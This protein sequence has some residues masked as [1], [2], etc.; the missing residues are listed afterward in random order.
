VPGELTLSTDL[1]W[2]FRGV[3]PL[4][5]AGVV[6]TILPGRCNEL[7]AEQA[8]VIS[9]AQALA[10]HMTRHAVQAK[11]DSGRW[12]RIHP[13]VYAAFT[14]PLPRAA[15]IWAAVLAAGSGA[16]LSHQTAAELSGLLSPAPWQRI[17]VTVPSGAR[18][19]APAGVVIHYSRRVE[20]ARH[21][22]LLPPRTRVE[23]TVLDLAAGAATATDAIGWILS[24][25]GSRRTT[26]NRLRRVMAA[27]SGIRRRKLLLAVLGEAR[28]GVHSVLE[29][30]YLR[31]VELPHGLPRGSRQ[32]RVQANG[33]SRYRD[34]HYRE[35]DLTVELDGRIAHPEDQRW[36]DI[37]RDN[38]SAADGLVTLRYSWADVTQRP[39][40]VAGEVARTLAARGWTGEIRRCGPGCTAGGTGGS[41]RAIA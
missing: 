14:G 24:A 40:Q 25:C 23:E 41:G 32:W 20:V 2:G 16:V 35:F 31:R 9:R 29:H 4:L 27:R 15:M 7:L 28:D 36:R 37:R 22:A 39:C 8:G 18:V 11:L 5:N 38:E 21:P 13:G 33:T 6:A 1:S 10:E 17:H 3:Q 30:G 26:P 34:V 19:V 12:Q